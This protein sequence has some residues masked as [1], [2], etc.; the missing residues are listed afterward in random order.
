MTTKL[1]ISG[2][3]CGNCVKHVTQALQAVPGVERVS[4]NLESGTAEVEGDVSN[5]QLRAAIEE[6]GYELEGASAL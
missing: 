1:K 6:E 3:T 5:E 2:M 4:V